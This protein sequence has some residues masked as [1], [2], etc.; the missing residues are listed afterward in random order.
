[1]T[2]KE[3]LRMSDSAVDSTVKI[4]GTKFDRK[5]TISQDLV[6]KMQWLAACGLTPTQIAERCC[7]SWG[8]AK[9]HTDPEYRYWHNRT[10]NSKHY[11]KSSDVSERA[12]YKRKLVSA[13]AHVIY[14]MA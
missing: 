1:M 12:S 9:Y 13:N 5:W 7:V 14:P 8:V 11:G 4:Q 2:K 10:K 3:V 6:K